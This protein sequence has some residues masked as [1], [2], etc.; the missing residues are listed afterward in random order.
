MR[1]RVAGDSKMPHSY[2]NLLYHIVFS[3]KERHPFI[4][5]EFEERLYEYI[6]GTI[7]GLGGVCLEIGGV[8]DHLHI[9]T[10]LKPTHNV[11]KFLGDLKPAVT[12]WARPIIH[13]KF[14]WQDGYGAFSVGESQVPSVRKYIQ[15]QKE[16]HRHLTFEDEFKG[17]LVYSGIEFEERF[18]WK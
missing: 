9:L 8:D 12:V 13:P 11:S 6:G 17:M 3:T 18:L 2:T 4:S 15:N 14:E 1:A 7:R 5:P 10:K 16:H